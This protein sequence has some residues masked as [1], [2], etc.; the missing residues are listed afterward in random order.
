MWRA[1][2]IIA[3]FRLFGAWTWLPEY[4]IGIA[5]EIDSA[6]AYRPLT[7]L[8]RMFWGLYAMLISASVAIFVFTLVVNRMQR[9]AQKAAIHA[10]E[11]GQYKWRR[12]SGP[13]RWALS[14]K[15]FTP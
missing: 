14:T 1:T 6:E 9:E 15:G 7:V 5:T 2:L 13:A 11:L 4:E 10:Q 8:S 12:N 3:E